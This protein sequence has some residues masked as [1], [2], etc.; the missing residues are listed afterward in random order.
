MGFQSALDDGVSRKPSWESF[1]DKDEKRE[2][3]IPRP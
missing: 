1:G 2:C 3:D